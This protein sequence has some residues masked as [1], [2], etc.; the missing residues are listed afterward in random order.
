MKEFCTVLL[1]QLI[2]IYTDHKN[3]TCKNFNTDR[4]LQWRLVLEEYDPN[5]EYIQGAMNVAA[6]ALSQ[7][8]NN[9][10]QDI[11]H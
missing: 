7:L 3:L 11:T 6:D 5:I 9:V 1:G 8:P 10:N 4:V 2:K